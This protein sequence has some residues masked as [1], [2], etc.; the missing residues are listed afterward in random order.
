MVSNKRREDESVVEGER[1]EGLERP[2]VTVAGGVTIEEM[3]PS[4]AAVTT[5]PLGRV[6]PNVTR[7]AGSI[8]VSG[9]RG[10]SMGPLGRGQGRFGE[11]DDRVER[12]FG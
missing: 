1:L 6:D 4:P 8:H 11:G 10:G 2:G 9:T 3:P 7:V 12:R 5:T